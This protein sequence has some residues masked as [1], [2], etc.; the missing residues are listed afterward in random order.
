MA[1]QEKGTMS[2]HVPGVDFG[3]LAKQIIAE[4]VA[5]GLFKADD[6]VRGIVA[7]ALTMKVDANGNHDKYNSREAM[8]W[9]EWL[10]KDQIRKCVTEVVKKRI[11]AMQPQLE[12]AVAKA[13]KDSADASAQILVSDF[14]ERSKSMYGPAVTVTLTAPGRRDR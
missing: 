4:K 6:I 14:V 10:T 7:E 8:S 1:E 11:E 12:K 13:L 5:E 9:L 2:L 3:L